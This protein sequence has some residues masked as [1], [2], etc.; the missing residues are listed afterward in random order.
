[1]D[2][3]LLIYNVLLT[4]MLTV[5]CTGFYLIHMKGKK[6]EFTYLA[7]L[8][9]LLVIDNTILLLSEFSL[10]FANLY[11]T[12][13]LIFAVIYLNYLGIIMTIRMIMKELFDKHISKYESVF[14]IIAVMILTFL[15]L[16]FDF[17]IS[18]FII[19]C[20]FFSCIFY[21]SIG[22]YK[23]V[24]IHREILGKGKVKKYRVIMWAICILSLAGIIDNGAFYAGYDQVD[25]TFLWMLEFRTPALDL[26]KI[27]ICL[28]GCN[29]LYK[30]FN[31]FVV[32]NHDKMSHIN[33]SED[34]HDTAVSE[35]SEDILNKEDRDIKSTY[36]DKSSVE[37]FCNENILTSRQTEIVKLILE[38]FSNK[39]ISFELK[40]TEGTVK[41]HV[42]NVFKKVEVNSRSQLIKK[43][44]DY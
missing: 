36:G 42:Y 14:M 10:N 17:K 38:G 12:S 19:Y 26:M 8:Y 41:A 39:E 7:L 40:I 25:N 23:Q 24:E 18:E 15:Y 2:N 5:V 27:M 4:V 9:F 11:E 28:L 35:T 22:I 43:I 21:L 3:V 30:S 33:N 44:L 20:F 32:V 13:D 34:K 1:M 37:K 16:S 6:K 29:Y 31:Q